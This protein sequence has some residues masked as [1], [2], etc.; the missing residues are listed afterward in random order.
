M[1][2]VER[3]LVGTAAQAQVQPNVG[4]RAEMN[5]ESRAG[6]AARSA[7][8]RGRCS[9]RL[10]ARSTRGRVQLDRV[11]HDRV[12]VRLVEAGQ[13][14]VLGANWSEPALT[15][16]GA[17]KAAAY[18]RRTV[19]NSCGSSMGISMRHRQHQSTLTRKPR[20]TKALTPLAF[21]SR[22]R[23]FKWS[24][25]LDSNQRPLAP[26][27]STYV[28]HPLA[29]CGFES[30]PLEIPPG[31]SSQSLDPFVPAPSVGR[32]SCAPVVRPR[33]RSRG[34]SRHQRRPPAAPAR[35]SRLRLGFA[36]HQS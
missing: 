4:W 28:P 11:M 21:A 17:S 24:G 12:V 26:Q 1:R 14:Q 2:R 23:A 6:R 16:T 25:R 33:H 7:V 9:Q 5:G 20:K 19:S 35:S 36:A 8:S 10:T 3:H 31:G 22:I 18:S 29:G 32:N 13:P 34:A 15:V 30:Q 27:R